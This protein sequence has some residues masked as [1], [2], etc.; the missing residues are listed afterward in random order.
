M[1]C[2]EIVITIFI[3]LQI[4]WITSQVHSQEVQYIICIDGG[5]SKTNMQILDAEYNTILFQKNG[6]TI[7]EYVGGS[8]NVTRMSSVDIHDRCSDLL[9]DVVVKGKPLCQLASNC[10]IIGGFAGAV[11]EH[12][13]RAIKEIIASFGFEH[14]LVNHDAGILFDCFEGNG[15][16]LI[17]GTGSI[18][19]A[20]KDNKLLRVGGLGCLLGDEGSG[21]YIGRLAIK[22]AL[23][24]EYGYGPITQLRDEICDYFNF[25][26]IEQV[27]NPL[28]QGKITPSD[29]AALSSIV[30]KCASCDLV[31]QAI[32]EDAT[33][34]LAQLL[35]KIITSFDLPPSF[36]FCV[37]G[38]FRQNSFF[39]KVVEKADLSAW[40]IENIAY[41]NPIVSILRHNKVGYNLREFS[42]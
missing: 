40:H 25:I 6:N 12:Q 3:F 30:F 33:D 17:A 14:V 7:E 18:C 39:K 35:C 27:K 26:L 4:S 36:L 32:I 1:T 41:N 5:G 19:L 10:K 13:Q 22:A 28:H 21:Y 38:L 15:I 37:G 8:F 31:A 42:N 2:H 11:Q 34:Q 23:E 29:V 20:R 24:M 9:S 16:V